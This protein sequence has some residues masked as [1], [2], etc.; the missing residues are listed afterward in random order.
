MSRIVEGF[1]GTPAIVSMLEEHSLQLAALRDDLRQ[2]SAQ[3]TDS[4]EIASRNW[5][6][7]IERGGVGLRTWD[8]L[9]LHFVFGQWFEDHFWE[10]FPIEITSHRFVAGASVGLVDTT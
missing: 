8:L 2:K 10:L 1:Y 3:E 9:Y 6:S 4:W 5:V 7:R